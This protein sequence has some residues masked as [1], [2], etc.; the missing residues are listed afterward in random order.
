MSGETLGKA[1]GES[2]GTEADIDV[3]ITLKPV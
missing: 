2:G 1:E 3:L